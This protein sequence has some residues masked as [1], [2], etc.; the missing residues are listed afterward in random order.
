MEW[1]SILKQ[2]DQTFN[3]FTHI[4]IKN[5]STQQS[6]PIHPL[7]KLSAGLTLKMMPRQTDNR[8]VILLPNR[9]DT[10]RWIATLCALE[11]MRTDYEVNFSGKLELTRG[12]KLLVNNRI[13]EF[14][15]KEY[16]PALKRWELWVKCKN[17]RWA[18]PLDRQL[19]FQPTNTKR[20]LSTLE[21][22]R[23]AYFSAEKIDSKLDLI[24]GID[25]RGNKSI[26]QDNVVLVSKIGET[27]DFIHEN[28]INDSRITDLFQ[29]GKLN[30]DGQITALTSGQ[31]NAK[32]SSLIVSDLY[33][34]AEYVTANPKM[35]KIIIID[36]V[37]SC[38]KDLQRLDDD[39]LPLN[40]PMIV[41]ADLFETE[42]L[43]HLEDRNFK[44]WQWNKRTISRKSVVS[45]GEKTPFSALNCSLKNYINQQ[46]IC[47]FC[48]HPIL[49]GLVENVLALGQSIE[50]GDDHLK[51]M[52]VQL[53]RLVNRF[54]RL[55]WLPDQ[56]W[57][58]DFFGS[59]QRLQQNFSG[60]RL[61]I[62]RDKVKKIETSLKTLSDLTSNPFPDLDHKLEKLY[63]LTT[64]LSDSDT[65]AIIVLSQRDAR[66]AKEYWRN[67]LP[68]RK[69]NHLHFLMISDLRDTAE[70]LALTQIIICGWL[71]HSRI[72][73]LLHMNVVPKITMLLYP[74]EAQWFRSA[75]KRW[76]K[77][78]NYHIREKDFSDTLNF[79]EN[80]LSLVDSTPEVP[81][82][83]S[84]DTEDFD[85]IDFELRVKR[86]RYAS[87][88]AGGSESEVIKAKTVAFT[89]DRFA[90]ITETH[91]LLVVSDFMR[92]KVSKNSIPRRDIS[93]LRVGDYV[94][95][96]E[97]DKDIIREI[98]DKALAKKEL[99]HL[100]DIA[101]LWKIA[102]RRRYEAYGKD[103]EKLVL[104]LWDAGCEREPSTINSWL[105]NE[106]RI[107]P[108][109][110]ED[111]GRIARAT[112]DELLMMKQREVE[113]AIQVVRSAHLQAAGYITRRLL[114]NLS[115]ILDSELDSYTDLSPS[116]G[117]NLDDFGHIRILRVDEIIDEWK[118]YD[119][120]LVNRLLP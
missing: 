81:D 70:R 69:F 39:I 47:E 83:A 91:H 44:I 61:W 102:L 4:D 75:R 113:E 118:E 57:M 85:I 76:N 71:N 45:A 13:V 20:Q 77:Q 74:F 82:S 109:N 101:S 37:A 112:R 9:L 2:F 52:Y 79:S 22:V 65:V 87:Y 43:N 99:G 90:F 38:L 66:A 89:Q 80:D 18:L 110:K 78:N 15:A 88:T 40:I 1:D 17:G 49:T 30:V 11:V 114:D 58:S 33:G 115:E 51:N 8:L 12:Q 14:E 105:W 41:V 21:S 59:V 64:Q 31:I 3:S 106:D 24:L 63:A 120:N 5:T 93:Q 19:D 97:S 95:F 34:A 56:S 28:S 55:V 117:L 32:P 53:V 6:V 46:I 62:Q 10:A 25:S 29:W 86:Y 60:Q 7:I 27:T 116:M 92:G 48:E 42:Q 84:S 96:R 35:T 16:L 26:F 100:R 54:S 36:G 94:L 104:T 50:P 103:F 73:P 111:I 68:D 23:K 108:A 98:A 119:V 67:Q 107:G 72:Y